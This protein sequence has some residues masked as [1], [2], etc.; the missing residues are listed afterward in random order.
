MALIRPRDDGT[1]TSNLPR[2][3]ARGCLNLDPRKRYALMESRSKWGRFSYDLRVG[4]RTRGGCLGG[5]AGVVSRR[6]ARLWR[7]S[8]ICQ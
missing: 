3:S 2:L 8:A 7:N 5:I 1:L 4:N 6:V